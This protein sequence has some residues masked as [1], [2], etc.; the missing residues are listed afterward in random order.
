[1]IRAS[2]ICLWTFEAGLHSF[3]LGQSLYGLF[4]A[5]ALDSIF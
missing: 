2:L 1:M 5:V 4:F 3:G